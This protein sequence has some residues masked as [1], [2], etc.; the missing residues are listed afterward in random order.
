MTRLATAALLAL[1]ALAVGA[2][3]GTN[4]APRPEAKKE[5]ETGSLDLRRFVGTVKNPPDEFSVI[6]RRPLEMPQNYAALPAPDPGARSSRLPD[7][8][9]EARAALLADARPVAEQGPVATSTAEAAL[10]GAAGTTDPAIRQTLEGEEVAYREEQDLYVLDRV[11][12]VLRTLRGED[13]RN[14]IAPREE[15]QRLNTLAAS[16]AARA[17]RSTEIAVIPRPASAATLDPSPA[18]PPA[19]VPARPATPVAPASDTGGLIYLPQ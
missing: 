3:G 7:P 19:A 8:V 2:C 16:D 11:F 15:Y 14:I 13:D 10:L 9:A 1:T 18:A 6:S 12:P 5:E 4:T 17:A